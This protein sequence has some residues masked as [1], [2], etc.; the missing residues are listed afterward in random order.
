M[1]MHRAPYTVVLAVMIVKAGRWH[2]SA[3]LG[4]A[5]GEELVYSCEEI[6]AVLRAQTRL[7]A[8]V[9]ADEPCEGFRVTARAKHTAQLVGWARWVRS[10]ETGLLRAAPEDAG[11][12]TACAYGEHGATPRL[13]A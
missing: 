8:R 13:A 9:L 2:V 12:W 3:Q 1:T 10:A 5:L 7:V 11:E 6:K 4:E